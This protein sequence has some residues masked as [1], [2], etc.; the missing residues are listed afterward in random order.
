MTLREFIES[1][2]AALHELVQLVF[3]LVL[4]SFDRFIM[5]PGT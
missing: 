5:L 2:L 3:D 4:C 1:L